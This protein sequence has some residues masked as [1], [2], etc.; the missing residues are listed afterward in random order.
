MELVIAAA[1]MV[2]SRFTNLSEGRGFGP[3]EVLQ[4]RTAR[5]AIGGDRGRR[6]ITFPPID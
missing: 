1:T 2:P 5:T 3:M 6:T 4:G